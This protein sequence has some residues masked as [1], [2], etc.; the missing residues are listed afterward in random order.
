M[1]EAEKKST[2]R[3]EGTF[4]FKREEKSRKKGRK[5]ERT[6]LWATDLENGEGVAD[7]GTER[8]KVPRL[9]P[10]TVNIGPTRTQRG[11]SYLL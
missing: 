2:R 6:R 1:L 7:F 11:I 8:K 9:H 3:V 4:C 10:L 5:R